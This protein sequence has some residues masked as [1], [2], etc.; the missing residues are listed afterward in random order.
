MSGHSKWH[1]IRHKKGATD[2]KRGKI[3]SRIN[4]EL[5]VA[6]RMGG[7]DPSANPRLRQ[8]IA[9][10][11]AENMPKDNIERAIKKGTGELEG[12]NYEEHVY[13]GYAPGGVALLI[14][15]MT[16]NKNRAAADIR[17]V[18]N[19]RGGSLGEAGCVA[20]MFDKKGLIVFEQELV[21]EDEVLEVALEAG[22]D[23]VITTEDQYEVHTEL[24]AFESVKQAF[25]D[26]ELRYT[27]AEI[28][29]MP[30]NT[31]KV[32]DEAQAAQVLKLMDAIE[33][34]DDVQKVYANFDIPDEIL[35][36][37]T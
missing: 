14:E 18:F 28:T 24:A 26:Q 1:S 6:A 20:W 31:V 7:G 29:M 21:D 8:A 35:Q 25:D 17:Y 12:V 36:R 37:I 19:K 4:K 5:M 33:D 32:D 34:A 27:M 11:K 13:E 22:A 15:V 9:T 16:D 10:A 3:F 2:A 30:Q 23:D